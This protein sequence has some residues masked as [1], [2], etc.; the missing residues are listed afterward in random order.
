MSALINLKSIVNIDG[1]N[2]EICVSVGVVGTLGNDIGDAITI[3]D[4]IRNVDRL[5]Y[6]S[7]KNGGSCY[8]AEPLS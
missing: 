7:E 3:S 2:C 5:T 8:S 6:N 4:L 1:K